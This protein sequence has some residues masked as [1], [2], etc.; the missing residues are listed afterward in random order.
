MSITA[1]YRGAARSSVVPFLSVASPLGRRGRAAMRALLRASLGLYFLAALAHAGETPYT[2]P[3]SEVSGSATY[4]CIGA[5][6]VTKAG[7][8]S[9]FFYMSS[10]VTVPRTQRPALEEAWRRHLEELHPYFAIAPD[11]CGEQPAD[12][13]AATSNRQ[14]LIAQWKG[15]AQI[16]EESFAYNGPINH[17]PRMHFFC[18]S[19]S[20]DRKTLYLTE[21]FDVAPTQ[22][23]T[24]VTMS[25]RDYAQ[26][27]LGLTQYASG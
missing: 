7:A 18:E 9:S 2:G 8:N 20:G 19:W 25:W 26:K 21:A 16:V 14:S 23:V 1:V 22:D 12:A 5:V 3:G 4:M 11:N 13:A 6:T 27:T 10:P 15:K 24:P 17:D